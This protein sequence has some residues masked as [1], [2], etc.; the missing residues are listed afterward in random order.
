MASSSQSKRRIL[1]SNGGQSGDAGSNR[2]ILL[3][4]GL[5][6]VA[7]FIFS[8]LER[9]NE[10]AGVRSEIALLQN[11]LAQ[12]EQRNAELEA[13]RLEVAGSTYVA[14]TARSELGLIQSGDDPFVILGQRAPEM[15]ASGGPEPEIVPLEPKAAQSDLFDVTW[16]RSLFG[17]Q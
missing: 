3:L 5:L 7:L 12:A 17:L 8:Y 2:S 11:D 13:T 4:I 16:W 9:I 6:V 10:L 15:G 1:N 14:E